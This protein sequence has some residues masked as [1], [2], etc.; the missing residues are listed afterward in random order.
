MTMPRSI[1]F[2]PADSEKK[3]AKGLESGA[4]AL[5]LDLAD[6]VAEPANKPEARRLAARFLAERAKPRTPQLWVR[7]NP[8]AS[9]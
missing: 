7:I 2:I 8:L 5:V 1:L 9:A 6:A 3:F 4:D